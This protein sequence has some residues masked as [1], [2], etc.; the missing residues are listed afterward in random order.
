ML[1]NSYLIPKLLSKEFSFHWR[2]KEQ[3]FVKHSNYVHLF[4]GTIN[5]IVF[6]IEWPATM[7]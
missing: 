2:G 6:Y 1:N 4:V 3:Y 7:H 5:N